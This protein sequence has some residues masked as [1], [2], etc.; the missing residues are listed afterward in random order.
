MGDRKAPTPPP[1]ARYT[2]AGQADAIRSMKDRPKNQVKP[3][4]PPAPPRKEK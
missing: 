4:A 3:A 1:S 2:A